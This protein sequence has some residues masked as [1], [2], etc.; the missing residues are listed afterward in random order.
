[1]SLG[2]ICWN[3]SKTPLMPK[4][5]EQDDQIAP[6][7]AVANIAIMV[8]GILGINPTTLSFFTIPISRMENAKRDT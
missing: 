7:L 3:L 5:G 4:S 8:S 1:M 2:S 6:I